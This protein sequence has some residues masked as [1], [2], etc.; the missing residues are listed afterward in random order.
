M[1]YNSRNDKDGMVLTNEKGQTLT[2]T[3][4]E[5]FGKFLKDV[6]DCLRR[7]GLGGILSD[8]DDEEPL[9]PDAAFARRDRILGYGV[10]TQ[11]DDKIIEGYLKANRE[12]KRYCEITLAAIKQ[13]LA[14]N[15]QQ[16]LELHIDDMS[17]AR[18]TNI[19]SIITVLSTKY[20]GWSATKGQRNFF[21]MIAI[22]KFTSIDT[23]Q[24][25]LLQLKELVLERKSWGIEMELFP[26]S[27]YDSG[28]YYE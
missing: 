14:T 9:R 6:K 8:D 16:Y 7:H 26:D 1:S 2:F 21:E 13:S 15:I 23:V 17:D 24:S 28:F 10:A 19:I 12:W 3:G 18:K 5:N 20:G 25:G 27:H 11:H 4:V 22:P